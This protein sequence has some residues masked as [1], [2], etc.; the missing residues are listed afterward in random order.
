VA[1]LTVLHQENNATPPYLQDTCK[2]VNLRKSY[3]VGS[4]PGRGPRR[5][6]PE[7]QPRRQLSAAAGRRRQLASARARPASGSAAPAACPVEAGPAPGQ[8]PELRGDGDG[9]AARG[10]MTWVRFHVTII[11][12]WNFCQFSAEKIGFF[13]QKTIL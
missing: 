6:W 3:L 10:T 13:S 12:F 11:I 1:I 2:N 9:D 5:S 4:A 8:V 7:R